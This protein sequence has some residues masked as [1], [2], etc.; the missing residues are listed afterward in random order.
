[1]LPARVEALVLLLR[2]LLILA[3]RSLGPGRLRLAVLRAG[4][5]LHAF[6]A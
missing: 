4:Y 2:P 1:M 5:V 3:M 6:Q